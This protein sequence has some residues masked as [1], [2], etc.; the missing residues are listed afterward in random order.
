MHS[1]PTLL[2]ENLIFL[3]EVLWRQKEQFSDGVGYSWIDSL[4]KN[5]EDA[6]SD[7]RMEH[8][9]EIFPFD[10]P[11]TK[12]ASTTERF[13]KKCSWQLTAS[14]VRRWIPRADWG[15][16]VIRQDEHKR[17]HCQTIVKSMK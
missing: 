5:A 1:I 17:F 7:E 2:E 12:E 15:C 14:T 9:A 16:P 10:T 4:K 13:L 3:Q 6:V 11:T 8:A